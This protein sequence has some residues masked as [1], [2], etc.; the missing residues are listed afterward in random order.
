MPTSPEQ[1]SSLKH[2]V[3]LE[4]G[5]ATHCSALLRR[6]QPYIAL[7]LSI[8]P[9]EEIRGCTWDDLTDTSHSLAIFLS[10]RW[11]RAGA[12][13]FNHRDLG[14]HSAQGGLRVPGPTKH[15]CDSGA[16]Q[17]STSVKNTGE[18]NVWGVWHVCA[19]VFEGY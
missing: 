18:V 7:H 4:H 13:V 17:G 8:V 11:F 12:G 2:P 9:L 15:H 19:P 3:V 14:T 10:I 6:T 16:S 5:C 1:G